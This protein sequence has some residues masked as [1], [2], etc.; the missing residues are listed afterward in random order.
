MRQRILL[1]AEEIVLRARIGRALLSSGYA[2]E[3]ATDEKRALKLARDNKFEVAIVAPGSYPANLAMMLELRDTVPEMIVLAE[4]LEEIARLHRSFPGS[5][6]LLKSDEGALI[7]RVR[8]MTTGTIGEPAPV[9]SILCMEDC[10]LD[11]AGHVF[12]T[13]DS[14]EVALTRAES[15]VL[16]ELARH[17]CRVSIA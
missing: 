2:V 11:L 8:E 9:P 5:A 17:P 1:V 15:E 7:T 4:R 12:I 16:K 3:L 13:A 10:R 14:R 6:V